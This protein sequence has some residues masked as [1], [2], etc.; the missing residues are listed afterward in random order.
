MQLPSVANDAQFDALMADPDQV[1]RCLE[2]AATSLG[3][4][5]VSTPVRGSALIGLSESAVIKLMAPF[6]NELALVEQ[7]CLRT[8][9]GALPVATPRILDSGTLD[10]WSYVHMTRLPGVELKECWPALDSRHKLSIATQLGECL[11]LLHQLP[12]PAEIPRCDWSS[13]ATNRVANIQDYLRD[14]LPAWADVVPQVLASADLSAGQ[15]GW[16]HT[17]VMLEH[18][19]VQVDGDK[20]HLSGLFDFEPSWV[21]P[22]HYEYASIAMFVSAGD[23]SILSEVLRAANQ[24]VSPERLFAMAMMHRSGKLAW[25]KQRLGG[26]DDLQTWIQTFFSTDTL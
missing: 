4:G 19:L 21:A 3:V 12:T 24:T 14:V 22:V 20:V 6:D 9:H 25:Y 13:W 26:P 2:Y 23:R 15:Q 5:P 8:L 10:G 1:A 16:L 17:E 7:V 18:L 11:Q